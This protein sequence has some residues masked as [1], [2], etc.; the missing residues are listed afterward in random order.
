AITQRWKVAHAG[1]INDDHIAWQ[2][3]AEYLAKA[4]VKY[5]CSFSPERIILGGGVM[6]KTILFEMIRKNVTKYLNNYLDYPTLK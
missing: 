2:F 5:I 1:A 3:E 6:H 4:I